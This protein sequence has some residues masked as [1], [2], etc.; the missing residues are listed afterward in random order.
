MNNFWLVAGPIIGGVI[1]GVVGFSTQWL[2]D[3]RR[4]RFTIKL[5]L[6]GL[7]EDL[8]HFTMLS[9]RIEEDYTKSK[10]IYYNLINRIY[11]SRGHYFRNR[12]LVM[13]IDDDILRAEVQEFYRHSND[14]LTALQTG[15]QRLDEIRRLLSDRAQGIWHQDNS[16]TFE[17]IFE[18]AELLLQVEVGERDG[19]N[20]HIPQQLN[21]L[22]ENRSAAQRLIDKLPS[23]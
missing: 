14:V 13:G 16:L 9:K 8:R 2:T 11:E 7:K 18:Q 4:R 17:Q 20:L 23:Q 1:S 12:D 22:R 6:Q 3:A 15:Q 10:T 19:L 21:E 5:F